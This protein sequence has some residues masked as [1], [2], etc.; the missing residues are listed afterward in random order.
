MRVL[1]CSLL[2]LS[3]QACAR[4]DVPLGTN[5]NANNGGSSNGNT[6]TTGGKPKPEPD[7]NNG[8]MNTSGDNSANGADANNGGDDG[9]GGSGKCAAASCDKPTADLGEIDASDPGAVL[10]HSGQGSA[11]LTVTAKDT[12]YPMGQLTGPSASNGA[13]GI[14]A[15]VSPTGSGKFAVYVRGELDSEGDPCAANDAD[16]GPNGK[17]SAL[18]NGEGLNPVTQVRKLTIEVKQT[19][20]D[21]DAWTLTLKGMPCML[22]LTTVAPSCP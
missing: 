16:E 18:W 13:I 11:F 15:T 3:L 7:A 2:L 22:G 19:E 1:V 17:T 20:G 6:N 5:N 21:C 9:G 8:D 12:N 14:S 4:D 10:M